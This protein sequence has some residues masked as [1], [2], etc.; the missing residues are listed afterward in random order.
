[1]EGRGVN[2]SRNVERARNAYYLLYSSLLLRKTPH[3]L[4]NV[5]AN[6][7]TNY[8]ASSVKENHLVHA[9]RDKSIFAGRL[10]NQ[11]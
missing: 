4:T 1:M 5:I 9:L 7:L 8:K 2:E 6:F 10:C 11:I 3:S